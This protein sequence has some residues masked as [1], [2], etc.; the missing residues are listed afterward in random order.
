MLQIIKNNVPEI[1][2]LVGFA[3]GIILANNVDIMLGLF[4][5]ITGAYFSGMMAENRRQKDMKRLLEEKE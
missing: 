1:I 4:V 3:L 2:I 5:S